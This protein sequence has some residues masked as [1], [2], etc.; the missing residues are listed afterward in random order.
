L[1]LCSDTADQ[2]KQWVETINAAIEQLEAN[3]RTLRKESSSRRPI[4]KRQLHQK[5]S[6]MRKFHQKKLTLNDPRVCQ[7]SSFEVE[8]LRSENT[9]SHSPRQSPTLKSTCVKSPRLMKLPKWPESC[10]GSPSFPYSPRKLLALI[11]PTSPNCSPVH[12]VSSVAFFF[13]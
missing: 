1:L 3:F 2:G 13:K 12:E 9:G 5:D 11:A 10:S 6:L 7:P 4:R 8:V